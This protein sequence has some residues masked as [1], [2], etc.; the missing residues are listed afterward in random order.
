MIQLK[1][2]KLNKKDLLNF[3]RNDFY[4]LIN[5]YFASEKY[6]ILILTYPKSIESEVVRNINTPE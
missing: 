5:A 1:Y 2:N 6:T 4:S 3:E